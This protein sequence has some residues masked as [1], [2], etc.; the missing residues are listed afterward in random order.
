MRRIGDIFHQPVR[1]IRRL[2][3]V[4]SSPIATIDAWKSP[5]LIVQADDDHSVPST[6]SSELLEDL[7]A[8]HVEHEELVIPNEMHDLARYASWMSFF[9]ATDAYFRRHL[10][11]A[12]SE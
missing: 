12:P 3:A 7:R 2:P 10:M 4:E 5:V 11:E 8:H 9:E 6:Q 1:A